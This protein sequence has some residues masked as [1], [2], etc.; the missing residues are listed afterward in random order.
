MGQTGK[1]NND[2][3]LF[4]LTFWVS[5]LSKRK[6]NTEKKNIFWNLTMWLTK[7]RANVMRKTNTFTQNPNN[8]FD[9]VALWRK[10]IRTQKERKMSTETYLALPHNICCIFFGWT[11]YLRPEDIYGYCFPSK[12]KLRQPVVL[13]STENLKIFSYCIQISKKLLIYRTETD[14]LISE[15]HELEKHTQQICYWWS[16]ILFSIN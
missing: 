12:V 8:K 6:K 3:K 14:K 1:L 16:K 13:T 11:R 15:M 10:Q 7:E 9:F 2:W 5:N 4:G